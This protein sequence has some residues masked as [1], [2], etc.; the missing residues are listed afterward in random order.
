MSVV[1]QSKTKAKIYTE[2]DLLQMPANARYELIRGELC[3][4]PENSAEH[5]SRTDRLA[6]RVSVFVQDND[7]GECFA[8]E[9]RFTIEKN[10]DTTL[11]PDFAFVTKDRLPEK[12]P[13]RGYL[14]LAP[15][16]ALETVSPNDTKHEINLKVARWLQAGTRIVWVLDPE[17]EMLTVHRTGEIPRTLGFKDTLSGEEV[18]P[19]FEIPLAKIFRK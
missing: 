14:P 11:G 10:P 12:L 8:A 16:I 5:G 17:T 19:G 15:D 4:M 18:L 3:P 6:S 1:L 13:R 2:E 9:T 7:L